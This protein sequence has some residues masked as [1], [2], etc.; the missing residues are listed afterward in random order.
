MTEASSGE[1]ETGSNNPELVE[2][3]VIIPHSGIMGEED[4]L[5]DVRR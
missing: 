5:S 1:D 3:G 4:L 2:D